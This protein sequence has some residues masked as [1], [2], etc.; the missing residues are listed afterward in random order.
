MAKRL[1]SWVEALSRLRLCAHLNFY[2]QRAASRV[3]DLRP[4]RWRALAGRYFP[5][6]ARRQIRGV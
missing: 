5:R 3:F 6:A 4:A 1:F 2:R